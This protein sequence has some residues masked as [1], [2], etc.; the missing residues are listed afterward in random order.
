MPIMYN[1][2]VGLFMNLKEL[3]EYT[4]N[5]YKGCFNVFRYGDGSVDPFDEGFNIYTALFGNF[6]STGGENPR[7]MSTVLHPIGSQKEIIILGT[8]NKN[9]YFVLNEGDIGITKCGTMHLF[10]DTPPKK[11]IEIAFTCIDPSAYP[12]WMARVMKWF[13]TP[14]VGQPGSSL[15]T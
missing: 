8:L 9:R 7:Y 15:Q 4:E 11:A 5:K 14:K 1:K 12:D 10:A 13:E 6:I 3:N 2:E